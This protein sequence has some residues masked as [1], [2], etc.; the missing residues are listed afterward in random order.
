MKKTKMSLTALSMALYGDNNNIHK[1]RYI[2]K[3]LDVPILNNKV[4]G[5]YLDLL[6]GSKDIRVPPIFRYTSGSKKT[7]I[8]KYLKKSK[9]IDIKKIKN[10]F[11]F[12]N[13]FGFEKYKIENEVLEIW[14]YKNK[15]LK[16][17]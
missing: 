2:C 10:L 4:S 12:N 11:I 16:V 13:N 7:Q 17:I 6:L 14:D 8:P 9:G 15:T 3:V 5:I 1:I